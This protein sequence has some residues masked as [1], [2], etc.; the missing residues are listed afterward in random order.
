MQKTRYYSY[1]SNSLSEGCELCVKGR[2]SVLFITG[3]CPESCYYCPISD[4]KKNKDVVYINEWPTKEWKNIKKEIQL[5]KSEGVGITGGDPLARLDRSLDMIK[6]LKKTFGKGFHIHLY[7][8]LTLVDKKTL[9][10]LYNSGLDEIR[11]HP[12]LEKPKRS[13]WKKILEARKFNW[14]LGV[15]IPVIPGKEEITKELVDFLNTNIDFL[16]LNELE[17]S[18]TNAMHLEG[19]SFKTKD[20]LSYAIKGSQALAFK[21]LKY[22][23]KKYPKMNVHYCTAKL[24][25]KVQMRNRIKLRSTSIKKSFDKVSEDGTLIRGAIYLDDSIKKNIPKSLSALK[26]ILEKE[27]KI[28]LEVDS[29]KR[30]LLTSE[31]TVRM[32][33]KKISPKL[34]KLAIVE[35]YPTFDAFEVEVHFLQ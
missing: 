30:R 11:F 16:N 33:S 2:K 8:P 20:K 7:I 25:D 19:K 10:K 4:Q 18:D 24:K 23:R 32:L 35:E 9:E 26:K 5:C 28:S 12:N 21:I 6:K 15:E 31:K 27:F 3:I 17:Y 29:R 22:I 14:K 13:E 1:K 34:F